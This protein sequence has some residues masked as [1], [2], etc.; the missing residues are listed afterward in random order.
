MHRRR[1][2]TLIELL[3]VIAIIAILAAI[4]F[5]VFA[6]A[7]EA[8]RK[9]TCISNL[10]QLGKGLM[11]YVQDYDEIYPVSNQE[12]DRMP[13]QQPH[14]WLGS[15]GRYPHLADVVA[16][17]IRN[18]GLFKCPTMGKEVQRA[19]PNNWVVADRGG[20]YGYRCFCGFGR[21]SNVPL[22]QPAAGAD[23]VGFL[24][25]GICRPIPN[26]VTNTSIGW[27]A[28][29]ASLATLN[30][31]TDDFLV[32]CNTFGIHHGETDSAVTSGQRVGGTPVV[33]MDGHAKFQP[34][35]LGGFIKFICNPLTN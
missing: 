23:L 5:P 32:F 33:Y 22:E 2:F 7:R 8:A 18:E 24:Q 20:S 21:P 27:T 17:Y 13:R 12:A 19:A 29:G 34:I 9:S 6:R 3:V 28:C 4:L 31:P 15:A 10:G 1:G 30:Q 26:L 25:L 11:M 35:D 16:P 14:V